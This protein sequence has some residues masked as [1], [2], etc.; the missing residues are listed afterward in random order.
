MKLPNLLETPIFQQ[1]YQWIAKPLD[2]M[3][4][5]VKQYPDIFTSQ[6]FGTKKRIIFANHPQAIQEILTNDRKKFTAPGE[7]NKTLQPLVGEYS[8]FLLNGSHHKRDRK[9]LMPQFHG[10]RM[11]TYGELICSLTEQVFSQLPKGEIFT[12]RNVTSEISLS[13]ILQAVFGL[14]EGERYQQIKHLI[15][16]MLDMFR[17]PLA[18]G[19]LLFPI[20]QK[21][22]G[23]F[24]PWGNFLRQR[25]QLDKLLYTEINERR[26]ELDNTNRVDILS[27]LMS[28][29]DEDG[30]SMTDQELRD[31]L[32]TLLL[33]GYETTATAMAWGL[34]WI[35]QKPEVREKLLQELDSL[36]ENPDPISISRLPYLTAICN[37]TLRI[38][39]VALATFVRQVQE[40]VVLSG[41]QIEP[42]SEIWGCIYLLHHREDL[43]PDSKQFKPERFIE[44]QFSPYEFMPF[45]NGA[46]RCIGYALAEFEMKLVLAKVVSGYQ[47]AFADNKPE[48][49]QRRGLTL[50]PAKGVKMKME[51]IRSA[52]SAVAAVG[53]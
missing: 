4:K 49:P 21:D 5:A 11:Q 30:N 32:M 19:F 37:E 29:T 36:G 24:S 40:P 50:A 15:I 46:R 38:Y 2:F 48:K 51:G 25:E 41:Y 1:R 18:F 12:A 42:G 17:S 39:P 47:L 10:E 6:I 44:R 7:A 27:L 20:L 16:A 8:L 52:Q 53:K 26:S 13:V 9:L 33:A 31:E 45:G 35:Y 34:Y 43:Y 23:K 14:Y 3:E 28:A 22:L